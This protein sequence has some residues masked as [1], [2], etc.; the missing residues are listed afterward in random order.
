MTASYDSMK[1]V[2]DSDPGY[3]VAWRSK[4][5]FEAGKYHD[6]VMTYGEAKKRAEE[7]RAQHPDMTFW[8]EKVQE[9][10]KPH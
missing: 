6:Q 3:V 7:L 8:A 5:Q 9:A 2:Q 1:P 10:F 4:Y